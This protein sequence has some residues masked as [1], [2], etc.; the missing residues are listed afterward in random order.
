MSRSPDKAQ[1]AA[2]SAEKT[3]YHH[4]DL[5]EALVAASYAQIA[6]VGVEK[7]SLADVCRR[8]GV[9]TAAPYKHFRDRDEILEVVVV[10][11]FDALGERSIAAV[12]AA[13]GATRIEGIIAMGEA[14]VTFAVEEEHLF[15]LMFGQHPQLKQTPQVVEDGTKCFSGVIEQV[16][17]YCAAND[18][19]GE[20]KA[21]AVRLWTFVH[22]AASLLIDE[23]YATVAP[24][25]DVLQMI[26]ETTPLMLAR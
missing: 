1:A 5:R 6:E 7:F 16:A 9:S 21:L 22:G 2:G 4:G 14:Y 26:R 18:V 10:R 13:G 17:C 24:E 12:E 20:P 15:R 3:R 8:A 11:A 25:L 23:D 19:A